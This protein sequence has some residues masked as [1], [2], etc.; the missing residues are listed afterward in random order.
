MVGKCRRLAGRWGLRLVSMTTIT[1]SD[2]VGAQLQARAAARGV[3]V[4]ELLAELAAG[5]DNGPA[6]VAGGDDPLEAFIGGSASGDP[7]SGSSHTVS[8]S[9]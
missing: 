9:P 3:S 5:L 1:V 8:H 4:E 2:A 6:V 7:G